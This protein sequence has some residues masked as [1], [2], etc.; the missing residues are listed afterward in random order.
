MLAAWSLLCFVAATCLLVAPPHPHPT[1]PLFL[2]AA[3]VQQPLQQL[4]GEAVQPH[5]EELLEELLQP[6]SCGFLEG[7]RQ[8]EQQME[9]VCQEVLRGDTEQAQQVRLKL[10]V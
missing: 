6:I 7:R 10:P 1:P 2:C 8:A 9:Q 3:E 4:C 5:L